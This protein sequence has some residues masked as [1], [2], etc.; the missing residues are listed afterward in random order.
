MLTGRN[1]VWQQ[2]SLSLAAAKVS[3]R[4]CLAGI[5]ELERQTGASALGLQQEA[6]ALALSWAGLERESFGAAGLGGSFALNRAGPGFDSG[7]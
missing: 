6:G 5:A 7:C 3:D 2:S 4:P 1:A